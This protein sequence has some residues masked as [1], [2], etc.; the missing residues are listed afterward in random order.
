MRPSFS[1]SDEAKI[2]RM[3]MAENSYRDLTTKEWKNIKEEQT[4]YRCLMRI[5]I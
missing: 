1:S 3:Q 4:F 5:A 2:F